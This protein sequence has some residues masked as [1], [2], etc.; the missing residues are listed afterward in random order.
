MVDE[1]AREQAIYLAL[2]AAG[3]VA[4]ALRAHLIEGHNADPG[5][6]AAQGT[7]TSS[8]TLLRQARGRLGQ[9]LRPS[10]PATAPG[11]ARSLQPMTGRR[12]G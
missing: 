12:T 8:L 7:C 6:A 11:L 3:V 5:R 1:I 10:R 9:G 4:A 2:K